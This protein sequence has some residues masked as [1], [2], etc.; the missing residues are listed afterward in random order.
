MDS[1]AR[2]HQHGKCLL[3][4][5]LL[6]PQDQSIQTWCGR[7]QDLHSELGR[8]RLQFDCF[9]RH[10]GLGTY[11]S[12]TEWSN[13][14][15]SRSCP[16]TVKRLLKYLNFLTID[17]HRFVSFIRN[18]F[19]CWSEVAIS[20]YFPTFDVLDKISLLSMFWFPLIKLLGTIFTS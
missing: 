16:S 4:R 18:S 17:Y 3:V 8:G 13:Y 10:E 15:F 6:A 7:K 20:V 19:F 12:E 11:P 1:S 9:F 14:S 2:R 5:P